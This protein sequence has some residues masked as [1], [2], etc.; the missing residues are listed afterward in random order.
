MSEIVERLR[1]HWSHELSLTDIYQTCKAGA[2]EIERL[3]RELAEARGD[4]DL[5]RK[6][7]WNSAIEEAAKYMDPRCGPYAKAI[8]ALVKP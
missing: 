6:E 7:G 4:L 3:T 2:D 5:E 1:K 8:R